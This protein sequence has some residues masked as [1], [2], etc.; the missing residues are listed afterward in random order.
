MLSRGSVSFWIEQLKAGEEAA[1][2]KLHKRYWPEVV[3]LARKRL[4]GVP[5]RACDD[6][7]VAQAAFWSFYQGLRAGRVPQLTNREDLIALLTHLV[8]CKAANQIRHE[9]GLQ[10]RAWF[11][12]ASFRVTVTDPQRP[13]LSDRLG[14]G[15]LN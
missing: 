8:A 3:R 4:R 10:K 12:M 1:L 11:N 14:A 6:E 15:F 13:C 9:V 2:A 5:C 7:D